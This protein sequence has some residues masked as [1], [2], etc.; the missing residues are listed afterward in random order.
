MSALQ[1]P[2]ALEQ[3]VDDELLR[4]PLL[5]DQVLEGALDQLRKN[6]ATQAPLQRALTAELIQAVRGQHNRLSDYFLRSLREQVREDLS[7]HQPHQAVTDSK[8]L[9]LALVDEEV[10]AM[11]VELS[12]TIELIKSQ[13]EY[14]LRELA[15]YTSALVGDMD[16]SRDHNPF[17]P[18]VYTRALGAATHG[19][20][21]SKGHQVILMRHSGVALAQ[22]L[23]MSYAAAVSRLEAQGVTPAAYRTVIL[24][25]GARSAGRFGE[26]TFSPDLHRMRDS[27]PAFSPSLD[28]ARSGTLGS[29]DATGVSTASS[30]QGAQGARSKATAANG[31]AWAGPR[32]DRPRTTGPLE[33]W[34]AVAGTNA[35]H[36]DRQAVELVSRL[37]EAMLDDERVP[38]DAA[39][40]IARLHG[41]AMRMALRNASLLDQQD[42]PLWRFIN[43]LVYEAQMTPGVNDPERVLLLKTAHGTADQLVSEPE[44]SLKL[45]RWAMERMESFLQKRFTRRLS[46]AS[47]HIGAL[48]KLEDKLT[49]GQTTPTT[50]HGMLDVPQLDTVPAALMDML[51]Q[52]DANA[53]TDAQTWLDS[54]VPGDWVRLFLQGRW[55]HVALLW[56]GERREIWLF[57]D[58]A[59]DATWAVRRGAL[60]MLHDAKL[61]KKLKQRS[62]VGTAAVRVQSQMAGTLADSAVKLNG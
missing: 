48:Q 4:A 52:P 37:F 1:V 17:R 50:M 40:V 41:P 12:H 42:H 34:S 28:L 8:P 45:Y 47:S 6:M 33:H 2:P 49:A 53:R 38:A 59:S 19:L 56:P 43:R 39:Q 20:S 61:G 54:L 13:C 25:S 9:A 11:D 27:A 32:Y 5:F 26:T 10:V 60:L 35:R 23:R 57:G 62:I 51:P 55:V 24:P 21:L 22:V 36:S 14:E 30:E 3:F 58:G 46:A 7:W 31:S 16:V 18:E 29:P 15:T 44:Q